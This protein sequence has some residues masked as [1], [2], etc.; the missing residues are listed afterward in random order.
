VSGNDVGAVGDFACPQQGLILH[1]DGTQWK[2]VKSPSFKP[3]SLLF[4]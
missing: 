2:H 3:S 4:G 1:W